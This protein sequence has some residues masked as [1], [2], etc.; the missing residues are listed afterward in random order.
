VLI[1]GDY[2]V[3][4]AGF[5]TDLASVPRILWSIIAPN[6]AAFVA[7]AILHDYLYSCGNLGDRRFADEV[8]YN[9]LKAQEVSTYTA[10]KF[11]MAVRLFGASH[12]N[13]RN[14]ECRDYNGQS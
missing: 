7:P 10:M 9:A 8:L 13:S 1:D 12:F 11:Y 5:Q 2:Y 14:M 6:Y 4:P 3:I